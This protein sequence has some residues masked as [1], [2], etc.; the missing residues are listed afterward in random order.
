MKKF[1]IFLLT[2]TPIK[3]NISSLINIL[4]RKY[5]WIIK[6]NKFGIGEM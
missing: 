5:L 4:L 2:E 1:T 3:V 6:D